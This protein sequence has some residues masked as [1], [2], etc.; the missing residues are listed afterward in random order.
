MEYS[1]VACP[2]CEA[3]TVKAGF[4]RGCGASLADAA[5]VEADQ[6]VKKQIGVGFV[7]GPRTAWEPLLKAHKHG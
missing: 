1:L 4:C 3:L 5:P 7:P 6:C 2:R